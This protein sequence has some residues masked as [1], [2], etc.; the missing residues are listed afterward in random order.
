MLE[1]D[2]TEDEKHQW[3]LVRHPELGRVFELWCYEGGPF[4]R[5]TVSKREDGSVVF[6]HTSGNMTSATT[7]TPADD[8]VAMDIVVDGPRAELR[9]VHYMGACMQFWHAPDF[10]RERDL[11]DF[12]ERCFIYT[13]RGPVG[14][15]DTARGKQKGFAADG[16]E[17]TP[18]CT[19]WYVPVD[20]LHPGDAWSF[21]AS[22]DRTIYGIVGVNSKDGR[23]LSAISCEH[24][25]NIGQGWHDC[26]HTV[27]EMQRYLEEAGRITHRGML[28]VMPN[29][30]QKLLEAF[31]SD[32][33]SAGTSAFTVTPQADGSLLLGPAAAGAPRLKLLLEAVDGDPGP[34]G[35]WERTYWGTSIR[36]G[37]SSRMW[38][39]PAG[40]SLELC[41]SM[42]GGPAEARARAELAGEGW[43]RGMAPEGVPAQVLHSTDG[44]WNA[45]VFWERS[46][47]RTPALGVAAPGEEGAE[48]VS[49]RGRLLIYRG[50]P[51]ELARRWA[52]A[53]TDWQHAVP[54]RMPVKD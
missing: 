49:V 13:M 22:G 34:A 19:Q 29:D 26:I 8:R 3:L 31:C 37:R 4:R 21:G 54:F 51:S 25:R 46:E 43:L 32:L 5:G 48:A 53:T 50:D 27:P 2:F 33:P 45:A 23:W 42:R 52:W 9:T 12:A 20:M 36:S 44:V 14:L 18:P 1:L 30:K 39:H 24:N 28:Y 7:F 6:E 41:V 16:P 11:V 10:M 47:E 17:N 15:M 40:D 35:G 38:A